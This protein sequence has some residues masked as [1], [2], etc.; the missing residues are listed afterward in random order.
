MV[1][2]D[3]RTVG[4]SVKG[5]KV[6]VL[7]RQLFVVVSSIIAVVEAIVTGSVEA[8]LTTPSDKVVLV[9]RLDVCAHLV[10]PFSYHLGGAVLAT[11]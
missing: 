9:K 11:R 10:D 1:G 2:W 7:E 8:A 6:D 5:A 3:V 4:V